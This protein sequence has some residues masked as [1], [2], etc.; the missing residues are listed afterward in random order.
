[1]RAPATASPNCTHLF[2][3]FLIL[4]EKP[5]GAGQTHL[6]V[7]EKG[8]SLSDWNWRGIQKGSGRGE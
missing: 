7:L 4:P 5:L 2:H 8:R 3:F 1:M 6:P